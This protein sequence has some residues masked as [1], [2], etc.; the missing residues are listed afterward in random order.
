MAFTTRNFFQVGDEVEVCSKQDGFHSSY[1]EA[2]V[3]ENLGDKYK[4]KYKNLVEEDD[5]STALEEIAAVDEVRPVCP[6]VWPDFFPG[7]RVD[8]FANDGWWAGIITRKSGDYGLSTFQ[9]LLSI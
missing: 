5:M 7:E 4:V 2:T 6:K 3:I 1:Y 9:A 8:A